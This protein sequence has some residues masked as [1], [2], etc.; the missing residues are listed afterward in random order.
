MQKESEMCNCMLGGAILYFRY[1][2]YFDYSLDKGN[3]VS[4]HIQNISL[5][6]YSIYKGLKA[7][8]K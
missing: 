6:L 1:I 4:I 8:C 7:I 3:L 2:L 5:Y